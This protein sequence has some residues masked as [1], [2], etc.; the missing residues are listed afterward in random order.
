MAPHQAR[1]LYRKGRPPE[2]PTARGEYS[3]CQS[4][5]FVLYRGVPV[6]PDLWELRS[7]LHAEEQETMSDISLEQAQAA[8][9]AVDNLLMKE[10][11]GKFC[12]PAVCGGTG[13]RSPVV[14][15]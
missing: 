15:P 4:P 13:L 7:S 3:H 5:G 14:S 6:R 1:P 10:C 8:W 11:H 12:L 2:N 9:Q